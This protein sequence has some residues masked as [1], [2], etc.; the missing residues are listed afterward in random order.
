MAWPGRGREQL[1][2][3]TGQLLIVEGGVGAAQR[4]VACDV[5]QLDAQQGGLQ[6]IEAEV[7][8][9]HLVKV[10]GAATMSAHQAR[11]VGER[12]VFGGEQAGI[13]ESAEVLRRKEREAAELADGP[14]LFALEAGAEG[15][16]GILDDGQAV[17]RGDGREGA[18]VGRQPEQ[19]YRQDGARARA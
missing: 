16:C 13:A 1:W 14:D 3:Q 7:A 15:L 19:V 10:L 12:I 9:D 6:R 17:G 5:R 4:G 2:L 11:A 18:H 8:A